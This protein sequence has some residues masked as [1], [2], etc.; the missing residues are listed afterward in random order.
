MTSGVVLIA[1][2]SAKYVKNLRSARARA[3][4]IFTIFRKARCNQN[5][6]ECHQ[7]YFSLGKGDA[8]GLEIKF[9]LLLGGGGGGG[10]VARRCDG[11]GASGAGRGMALGWRGARVR[12]FFWS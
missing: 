11:G 1:S 5:D 6:P 12:V 2:G 9:D 10:G 7:I 8:G 4:Q 3:P